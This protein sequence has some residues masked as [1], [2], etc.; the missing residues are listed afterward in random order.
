V[1]VVATFLKALV[2][3]RGQWINI[4]ASQAGRHINSI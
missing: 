3:M 1:M 4:S 2:S